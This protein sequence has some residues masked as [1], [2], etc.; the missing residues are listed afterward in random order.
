MVH[1]QL[2]VATTIPPPLAVC[3]KILLLL[4]NLGENVIANNH[5]DKTTEKGKGSLLLHDMTDKFQVPKTALETI[6]CALDHHLVYLDS[7][8]LYI[9]HN[10]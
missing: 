9:A 1:K 2:R 6:V 10:W 3:K 4:P 8:W 5:F 7:K